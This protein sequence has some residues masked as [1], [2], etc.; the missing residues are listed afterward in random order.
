[1]KWILQIAFSYLKTSPFRNLLT[2]LG[3]A[4]GVA[5]TS[6][7]LMTSHSAQNSLDKQIESRYGTYDLQFGFRK[8]GDYLTYDQL[9]N[10]TQIGGVSRVSKVLIP[11]VIPIPKEVILEPSY[12]GVEL[13]SP[14]M[15]KYKVLDGRYPKEGAEVAVTAAFANREELKIG[16]QVSF[17]FPPYGIKTAQVVGILNPPISGGGGNMAFFPLSW[18][19]EI[20]QLPNKVNLVQLDLD[21]G[22][23]KELL[24]SRI[25]EWFPDI[26]MDTRTYIDKASKQLDMFRPLAYG[27][28]FIALLVG[29]ILVMGSFILSVRSRSDHWAT[30]R[31]IGSNSRGIAGIVITEA[32][33]IGIVGSVIGIFVGMGFSMVAGSFIRQLL[34]LDGVDI[35]FSSYIIIIVFIL[36][37]LLSVFG[38]LIPALIARKV[39]PAQALRS[40][41][42]T[43]SQIEQKNSYWGFVLIAIGMLITIG[44]YWVSGEGSQLIVG[45]SGLLMCIGFLFAI[46]QL[47]AWI[48]ALLAAPVKYL[49]G[50]EATIAARN[51]IRYR[52][53]AGFAVAILALG[54]A[55]AL[56]AQIFLD[57]GLSA[58]EQTLR[59]QFPA[60]LV[61]RIPYTAVGSY[62]DPDVSSKISDITGI[63]GVARVAVRVQ[64]ALKDYN[65]S[66]SDPK[67]LEWVDHPNDLFSRESI[68]IYPID[69]VAIREILSLTVVEGASLN[70]ELKPGEAFMTEE[71]AQR[72][73]VKVGDSLTVQSDNNKGNPQQLKV[74][75]LLESYPLVRGVPYL[76]VNLDWGMETFGS[77]GFETLH[78]KVL[79]SIT[80]NKI[81]PQLRALLQEQPN[82]EYVSYQNT[83]QEQRKLFSQQMFL[84]KAS[85]LVVLLISGIGLMNAIMSSLYDRRQETG[86]I[87]AIGATPRQI[88]RIVRLEGM[89]MGVAA[90]LIGIAGGGILAYLLLSSIEITN[91][92]F[93]WGI[94]GVLLG[95]SVFLGVLASSIAA[96]SVRRM[97]P[98][99]ILRYV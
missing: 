98:S 4:L 66:K 39:P 24:A 54:L 57:S 3:V 27:L 71:M 48:V 14:E 26:N 19:Q 94:V 15:M 93:P 64:G 86:V 29:A 6:A 89:F 60:D 91:T 53:R 43:D 61:V 33:I 84:I 42:P 87:Q 62:L 31:A 12:W 21:K 44:N 8:Q 17:P 56:S 22:I 40:G 92:V 13:N 50:I 10:I 49:F 32:V 2:S 20:M 11:Y 67:W 63:E 36:G 59:K 70:A 41:L 65:F 47:F 52:G 7:L 55:I 18:T 1:M 51:V 85:I 75:A 78:I 97:T 99:E 58:M 38:A 95:I 82:A 88:L 68:E 83:I 46:P 80:V 77:K 23:N 9:H 73:G 90:G 72:L 79:S 76:F 69:T 74:I 16:D 81:E 28:G 45:I 30:L 25:K 35:S 96:N 5:L 34:K 37:V